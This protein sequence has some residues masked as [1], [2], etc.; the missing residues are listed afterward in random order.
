MFPVFMPPRA[1][2][3]A[4]SP[5]YK[6]VVVSARRLF[7]GNVNLYRCSSGRRREQTMSFVTG[8]RETTDPKADKNVDRISRNLGKI[9]LKKIKTALTG[10]EPA[11][12]QSCLVTAVKA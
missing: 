6:M 2:K 8:A 12:A 4:R 10:L 1:N 7:L 11:C 3:N 5:A 9:I